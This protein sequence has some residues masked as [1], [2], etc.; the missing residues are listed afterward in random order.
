MIRMVIT[1]NGTERRKFIYLSDH[2]IN[3]SIQKLKFT[4]ENILSKSQKSDIQSTQVGLV[5]K[6][7]NWTSGNVTVPA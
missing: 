5:R 6:E 1:L 7:V 3:E 4:L 2:Y